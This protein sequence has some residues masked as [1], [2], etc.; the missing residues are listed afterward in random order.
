VSDV[1]LVTGGAAALTDIAESS[2]SSSAFEA[3]VRAAVADRYEVIREI[4][5]G[6]MAAVFLARD[7]T[8]ERMVALKV[9]RPELAAGV[10]AARFLQEIHI[11]AGLSHP[12]IAPMLHS[13]EVAGLLYYV[14]PFAE[15][16][17]LRQRLAQQGRLPV[18]DALRIAREAALALDFAHRNGI[19]HRDV[20]PDNILLIDGQ[21]LLSDFGIARAIGEAATESLTATGVVIG[22]AH[23]M[24]PEQAAGQRDIDGR[25]DTYSLGCVLYEMLAGKPPFAGPSP[26]AVIAAH[27]TKSAPSV[28]VARPELSDAV[29][30]VVAKSLAREPAGRYQSAGELAVALEAAGH[31]AAERA[32]SLMDRLTRG[33][34]FA[35]AAVALMLIAIAVLVESLRGPVKPV[36][37]HT[38]QLTYAPG[39]EFEPAISPNGERVAFAA[40]PLRRFGRIYVRPTQG[41]RPVALTDTSARAPGWPTW[42]PDGQRIAYHTDAGIF[43]VPAAGGLSRWVTGSPGVATQRA[44]ARASARMPA[45]S[46]DGRLLA[47]AADTAIL[48]VPVEG[49]ASRI[50]TRAVDPSSPRWSPDGAWIAYTVSVPESTARRIGGGSAM[51][52]ARVRDGTSRVVG[53]AGSPDETPIWMP[54]GRSLLFVS[55]RGGGRDVYWLPLRGDGSAAGEAE[56][57]TTGARARFISLSKDG[58]QLAY[59]SMRTE[60]DLSYIMIDTSRTQ[61][62]ADAR[63]L[64]PEVRGEQGIFSM[65]VSHAAHAMVF[66]SNVRG[67]RD[68]YRMPLEGGQP[69][70]LTDDDADD[71]QPSWSPDG[72]Q[73]AFMSLRNG[74][75]EVFTMNHDGSG[76][77]RVAAARGRVRYPAWSPDQSRIV[78]AG[79]DGIFVIARDALGDFGPPRRLTASFGYMARWSPDGRRIAFVGRGGALQLVTLDGAEPT[80]LWRGPHD[81]DPGGFEATRGGRVAW[82]SDGRT[83]FYR[84]VLGL[85]RWS[86]WAV[87]VS[88]APPRLLFRIDDGRHFSG[89]M[90]E[91]DSARLYFGIGSSE[92]DLVLL[93]LGRKRGFFP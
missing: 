7:R 17:S 25:S 71:Y 54:D 44:A 76:Q 84:S 24:S 78:V 45:W 55:E 32:S 67:N 50:V 19:V 74:T 40:G 18:R 60:I 9:I 5:R 56:R 77:R 73:I 23:Y 80:T 3:H 57:V 30:R 31:S 51:R 29:E 34:W 90:I 22:T 91:A 65:S 85:G 86:L 81:V 64:A 53:D 4:G 52:V 16:Q 46:P 68:I 61:T 10:A 14:M 13:G 79:E 39:L 11:A 35:P 62:L 92:S 59:G 36:V 15:E 12:H 8:H 1:G 87:P 66:E 47:Y 41:G 27:M 33:R 2:E 93:T 48:A 20:K 69:D 38:T 37:E 49:G 89:D 72:K 21:A 70:H 75:R 6:G 83:V 58:R 88:R 26:Q 42:S 43:I 28:R 63:P 82:S